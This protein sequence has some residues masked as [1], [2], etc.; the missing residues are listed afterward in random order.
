MIP[1][2]LHQVWI[3][4]APIPEEFASWRVGWLDLHPGWE[5]HLWTDEN[6]DPMALTNSVEYVTASVPAMKADILRYE[7]LAAFGGVYLDMD[8]EPVK[9]LDDLTL[10]DAWVAIEDPQGP[11]FGNAALAAEA[12]HPFLKKLIDRL[13][14][15]V[16]LNWHKPINEQTGPVFM[17]KQ[18][19]RGETTVLPRTCFFPYGHWE[20]EREGESFPGAYGIHHWRRS[21]Q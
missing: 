19:A 18:W 5:H 15:N 9:A 1:R 16:T 3:G 14:D 6:V 2:I 7:M 4:D 10:T 12:G 8:V 21:W 17:T 11:W 13:P 20:A